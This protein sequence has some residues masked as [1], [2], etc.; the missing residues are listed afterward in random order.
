VLSLPAQDLTQDMSG[1]PA[2][3]RGG[4]RVRFG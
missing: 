1:I 4:L 3:W 2:R